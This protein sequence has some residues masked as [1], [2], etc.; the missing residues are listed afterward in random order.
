MEDGT[1]KKAM[2]LILVLAVTAACSASAI[3]F[4]D[5]SGTFGFDFDTFKGY[6]D[7]FYKGTLLKE[8]WT[9]QADE[10]SPWAIYGYADPGAGTSVMAVESV[11]DGLQIF[12]VYASIAAGGAMEEAEAVGKKLGE[13]F[14]MVIVTAYYA[15]NGTLPNDFN[16]LF[17]PETTDLFSVLYGLDGYSAEEL[18]AGVSYVTTVR[19]FPCSFTVRLENGDAPLY[20]LAIDVLPVGGTFIEQ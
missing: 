7:A 18:E 16:T 19:T 8:E 15:E 12:E 5:M 20:R 3:V 11:G 1:V 13:L 4:P 9:V 10:D 17:A 14:A 2:C 6:A